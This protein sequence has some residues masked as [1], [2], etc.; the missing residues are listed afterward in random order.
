M[1][2][3]IALLRVI[4][5]TIAAILMFI[6]GYKCHKSIF[7]VRNHKRGN[8]DQNNDNPLPMYAQKTN[9]TR[10]SKADGWNNFFK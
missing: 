7:E 9:K 2:F 3:V 1:E 8:A 4:L 5:I 10:V 6:A